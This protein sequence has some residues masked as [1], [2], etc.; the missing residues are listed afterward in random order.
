MA[1]SIVATKKSTLKKY[2]KYNLKKQK[3]NKSREMKCEQKDR[4]VA[5][6]AS[7]SHVKLTEP[8]V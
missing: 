6:C 1:R 3:Q 5:N 2:T 7:L 4:K 8:S